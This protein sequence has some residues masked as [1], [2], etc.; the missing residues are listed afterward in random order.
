MIGVWFELVKHRNPLFQSKVGK[1]SSEALPQCA[2]DVSDG[3]KPEKLN[4]KCGRDG[5][6]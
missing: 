5:H 4:E 3:S 2:V 1:P 6:Y